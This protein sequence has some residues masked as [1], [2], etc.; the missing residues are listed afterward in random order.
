LQGRASD[1]TVEKTSQPYS[2]AE[3]RMP[4]CILLVAATLSLGFPPPPASK[5]ASDDRVAIQGKWRLVSAAY[6]NEEK[7]DLDEVWTIT[8]THMVYGSGTKDAYTLDPT[9]SPKE[10]GGKSMKTGEKFI[11]IYELKGDE[12]KI[13]ITEADKA[14]PK[15]FLK[16]PDHNFFVLKRVKDKK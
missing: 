13:C 7:S 3:V 10:I 11:G 4:K 5:P 14:R 1:G 15:K 12:L 8:K 6:G 9:K 2:D 16:G